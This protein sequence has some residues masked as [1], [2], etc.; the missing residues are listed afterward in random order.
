MEAEY[1]LI[2]MRPDKRALHDLLAGTNVIYK[3]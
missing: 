2:A 1:I 3:R